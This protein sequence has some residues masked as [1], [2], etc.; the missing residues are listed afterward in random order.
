MSEQYPLKCGCGA[1]IRQGFKND[2]WV[3]AEGRTMCAS[4]VGLMAAFSDNGS[5]PYHYP[6]PDQEL[7]QE[8]I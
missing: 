7:E 6:R 8:A 5:I 3:D 2:M 1:W 4:G